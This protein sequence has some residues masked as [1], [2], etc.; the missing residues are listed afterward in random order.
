MIT[1]CPKSTI[2]FQ[3]FGA[4]QSAGAAAKW[5]ASTCS[6]IK[7]ATPLIGAPRF[8][9][10]W[11]DDPGAFEQSAADRQSFLTG[12]TYNCRPWNA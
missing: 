7:T 11:H 4:I 3:Q 5:Q 9:F 8:L 12:P 10:G 2:R 1:I 6:Q